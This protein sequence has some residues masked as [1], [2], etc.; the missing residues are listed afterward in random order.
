MQK[1][2]R[3][4]SSDVLM[5]LERDVTVYFTMFGWLD[6][7]QNLLKRKTFCSD[8]APL[9]AFPHILFHE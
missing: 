3:R 1:L 4:S 7:P 2:F 5:F 9:T 8:N 6:T